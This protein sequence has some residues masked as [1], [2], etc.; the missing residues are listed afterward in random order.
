MLPMNEGPFGVHEIELVVQTGPRFH[1]GCGVGEAA[2]GAVHLG[3]ISPWDYGGRLVINA[4]LKAEG[5]SLLSSLIQCHAKYLHTLKPVGHQ[6]T[7]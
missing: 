5:R 3:Q 1:D 6:S 2:D 4:H 7:N